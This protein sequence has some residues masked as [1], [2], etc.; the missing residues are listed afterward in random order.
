MV[1]WGSSEAGGNSSSVQAALTNVTYI[2]STNWA[3]AALTSHGSVVAWG[4]ANEGGDT[5]SV[6]DQLTNIVALFSSQTG[7][8]A[9]K[10]TGALVTWG[11]GTLSVAPVCVRLAGAAPI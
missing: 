7:F 4:R 1:T 11:Q 3:F 6:E 10:D 2:T 9:L 5:E 8:A